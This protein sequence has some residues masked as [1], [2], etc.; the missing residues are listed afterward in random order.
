[1]FE[2]KENSIPKPI[3]NFDSLDNYISHGKVCTLF[4]TG[5]YKKLGIGNFIPSYEINKMIF[6]KK[7]DVESLL[8]WKS[9]LA[10]IKDLS[11]TLNLKDS[12]AIISFLKRWDFRLIY[13]GKHPFNHGYMY[14][15][16]D[17]DD[18]KIKRKKDIVNIKEHSKNLNK[19]TQYNKLKLEHSLDETIYCSHNQACNMLETKSPN[20]TLLK[21][22]PCY[23]INK[24]VFHKIAEVKKY[25]D[26]KKET[27]PISRLYNELNLSNRGDILKVI[28][29]M[30]FKIIRY[31]E[32]PYGR[33]NL[34]Y[35]KDHDSIVKELLK[36][37]PADLNGMNQYIA[38]KDSLTLFGCFIS[39]AVLAKYTTKYKVKG[40]VYFLKRDIELFADYK[41][42]TITIPELV[43]QLDGI[44]G[45]SA[46][47]TLL[48]KE[49]I[50][51]VSA[52]ENP[53]SISDSVYISDINKIKYL[54]EFENKVNNEHNR[55][56][57][58]RLLISKISNNKLSISKTL[59]DFNDSFIYQRFENCN[60]T[61]LPIT[62]SQ[63]FEF[64][65]N[66]LNKDLLDY[67]IED[68]NTIVSNLFNNNCYSK[69]AK[70]EFV[71]F[72]NHLLER[73]NIRDKQ[74]YSV[75]RNDLVTCKRDTNSYTKI[76]L[77]NLFALLYKNL[78]NR[79]YLDKA[80]NSRS[81]SM[82]WLY[83]YLH[84]VT[85]WRSSSIMNIPK[86]N[87]NII[88]FNDGESFIKWIKEPSNTFTIEMGIKICDSIKRQVDSLNIKATKNKQSLV[89]E[90]GR[91]MSRGTGLL[92]ALCEAHRQISENNKIKNSK[93]T[94]ENTDKVITS[95][96]TDFKNYYK[97]FGNEYVEILGKSAFLN[98]K[99]NKAFNNY[100]IDYSEK[101]GD[102]LGGHI[103]SI[104][105]GHVV[106]VQGI[107]N[108]TPIY[109][110]RHV[111]K[112][113]EAIEATL[114]ERG[115]FGFAKFK[116]L[117][118]C[119]KNFINM[120]SKAQTNLM[121]RL[122][123]SP[124]ETELIVK[125][126]FTQ[127]E[128]VSRLITKM[129]LSKKEL[130]KELMKELAFGKTVAKHKHTRCIIKA[131]L[132]ININDV[133]K[134]EYLKIIEDYDN[135]SSCLMPEYDFCCGCPMLV[136]EIYFLY[137]LNDLIQDS[138]KSLISCKSEHE[139]YMYSNIILKS[140]MPILYEAQDV[141]GSDIIDTFIDTKNI[142]D[143]L[144]L[145]EHENKILLEIERST[146]DCS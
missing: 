87:L 28:T 109:E 145:L 78:D 11:S 44:I 36:E 124:F 91:L 10:P 1:M 9:Q 19:N 131:I 13:P 95:Y 18:I 50:K 24:F 73:H 31:N 125:S 3:S 107:S 76:Q 48:K 122:P 129:T 118:L 139:R 92:L 70:T 7:E 134:K 26:L 146:N 140:Y 43:K 39:M 137:E 81:C 59:L 110:T 57:K 47:K 51:I 88:G 4:R 93:N 54:V 102:G 5:R 42:N 104:M 119:D 90:A 86:P 117:S 144:N 32:H 37:A 89:F 33:M 108:T 16:A 45:E 72:Y 111:D 85:L 84:Y 69:N 63:T 65:S 34:Y 17:L 105:R 12:K 136:G 135:Y 80:I 94:T 71:N 121:N 68:T 74:P 27:Y 138:I 41:K 22:I 8:E 115:T 77:I 55:Y 96:V 114:F 15:L 143:N 61:S 123:V 49:Q 52:V 21:L 64:I 53:F 30:G 113:I 56:E 103:L 120:D 35:I 62:L 112:T 101:N 20:N 127:R 38:Y 141:L 66:T 128:I 98:I 29:K 132:N 130:I 67:S 142:I 14:Y 25:S 97:L 79:V 6:Y 100:T 116:L 82:V 60:D 106:N 133:E 126:V 2:F 83:M 46:L 58:Y 99:A 23:Y 75:D 40:I